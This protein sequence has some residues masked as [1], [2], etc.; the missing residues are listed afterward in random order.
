MEKYAFDNGLLTISDSEVG[1]S[2][3]ETFAPVLVPKNPTNGL[4][5]TREHVVRVRSF[6]DN[7]V[8]EVYLEKDEQQD[9]QYLLYYPSGTIK[10][11]C[12]YSQDE[13]HG[14]STLYADSDQ[15]LAKSWF[16]HGQRQG[17]SWW[18]YPTGALYS[19]QRFYNNVWHGRQEYYYPDSTLKTVMHYNHGVLH[20][21]VRLYS[22]TG[23]LNRELSFYD[24]QVNNNKGS[25]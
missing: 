18:Y 13:L 11:E 6:D 15:V 21:P 22:P 25:K 4:R 20:G 7:S 3:Q 17:K 19:I 10:M 2:F 23:S 16:F 8:E 24:G 14:P 1:V 12:Y 5:A 9:G